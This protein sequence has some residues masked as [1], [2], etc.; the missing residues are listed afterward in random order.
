VNEDVDAK[1][2]DELISALGKL[3]NKHRSAM[4]PYTRLT[5][6]SAY[7]NRDYLSDVLK[8]LLDP[9]FFAPND[10]TYRQ[11]FYNI[12]MRYYDYFYEYYEGL[13]RHLHIEPRESLPKKFPPFSNDDQRD[14]KS[15]GNVVFALMVFIAKGCDS[16]SSLCI[17]D[18]KQSEDSYYDYKKSFG[19]SSGNKTIK[20]Q[21][22][23]L[24]PNYSR[25]KKID[26][27][28]SGIPRKNVEKAIELLKSLGLYGEQIAHAKGHFFSAK[29]KKS[30]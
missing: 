8:Q 25:Y 20:E 9:E 17:L 13:S 29:P 3:Y 27:P 26:R 15:P 24:R 23:S 12:K 11:V 18:D 21:M 14:N 19:Y 10:D 30:K 28:V 4:F 5:Q 16:E 22:D 6:E 7:H 1:N 2:K